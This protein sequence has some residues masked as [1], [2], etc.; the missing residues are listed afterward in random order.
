MRLALL[1][2]AVALMCGGTLAQDCGAFADYLTSRIGSF[3]VPIGTCNEFVQISPTLTLLLL[4]LEC[5]LVRAQ[6]HRG[7]LLLQHV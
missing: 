3:N 6:D 1:A 4:P 2:L 7:Q 5:D